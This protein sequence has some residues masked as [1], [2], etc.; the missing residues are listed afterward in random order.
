MPVSPVSS[1]PP[2]IRSSSSHSKELEYDAA[3]KN[4]S[5]IAAASELAEMIRQKQLRGCIL[6]QEELQLLAKDRQRKDNHN[7]SNNLIYF[8]SK[9]NFILFY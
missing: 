7:M 9:I 4:S 5:A 3:E 2:N 1:P 8:W 6:T